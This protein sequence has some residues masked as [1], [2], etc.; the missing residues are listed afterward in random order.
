MSDGPLHAYEARRSLP[1]IVLADAS[2]SMSAD[3]K[4]DVLN[5][6]IETMAHDFASLQPS[7]TEIELAVIA[8]GGEQAQLVQPL[9]A[10]S[11]FAWQ[12]PRAA[13]RTPL[14]SA[15]ALART[16]LEDPQQIAQH[17]SRATL[18]LVSDGRPTDAWR[19]EL[20]ALLACERAAK[21]SRVAIAVGADADRP[22]LQA[23]AGEHSTRV[24][25]AHQARDVA[26]Y[27]LHITTSVSRAD[28]D[29]C[30]ETLD[31]LH[32]GAQPELDQLNA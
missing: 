2:G 32:L 8:F 31:E 12:P 15:L 6:S 17:A 11:S 10:A 27:F 16:L 30:R 7:D 19:P 5:A 1:V 25:E 9:L 23:F 14:G 13:G 18:V 24:L 29:D 21:A 22:M 20:D 28:Q 3:G 4:I 26:D